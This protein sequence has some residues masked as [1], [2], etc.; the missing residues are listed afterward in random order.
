MKANNVNSV[1]AGEAVSGTP[2]ER[3]NDMLH[4]ASVIV[5]RAN[6]LGVSVEDVVSAVDKNGNKQFDAYGKAM[7]AG[8]TALVDMAKEAMAEVQA[9]G[10]VTSATFYATPEAVDGLPKGVEMEAETTGHQYFTDPLNRN[11]LTAQGYKTPDVSAITSQV[12]DVGPGLVAGD[13]QSGGMGP[14]MLGS[15]FKPSSAMPTPSVDVGYSQA[16]DLGLGP[17]RMPSVSYQ[18]GPKRPN[19]PDQSVVDSVQMAVESVM[20]PDARVSITSGKDDATQDGS[21]R[22]GTGLAVDVAVYDPPG[23]R[24]TVANNAQQLKDI[25]QAFS[26]ITGG[27]VG[28][29]YTENGVMTDT[30]HMDQVKNLSGLQDHEWGLIGNDPTYS[31]ALAEARQNKTMPGSYWDRVATH[32][33]DAGIV[34]SPRDALTPSIMSAYQPQ[35]AEANPFDALLNQPVTQAAIA[36]PVAPVQASASMSAMAAQPGASAAVEQ[37]ATPVKTTAVPASMPDMAQ[38]DDGRFGPPATPSLTDPGRLASGYSP[39]FGPAIAD[40]SSATVPQMTASATMGQPVTRGF[41]AAAAV[42]AMGQPRSTFADPAVVGSLNTE[43]DAMAASQQD[44]PGQLAQFSRASWNPAPSYDVNGAVAPMSVPGASTVAN[45]ANPGFWGDLAA[46]DNQ[47]SA[48]AALSPAS[49]AAARAA[50]ANPSQPFTAPVSASMSMPSAMPGASAKVGS[51]PS[52]MQTSNMAAGI[53]AQRD[54]VAPMSVPGAVLS[55]NFSQAYNS[56]TNGTVNATATDGFS[57]PSIAPNAGATIAGP[58]QANIPAQ[59]YAARPAVS[60]PAVQRQA[61]AAQQ[62]QKA[63]SSFLSTV[64]PGIVGTAMLG[65]GAGIIG[66]L[67]G[68]ALAKNGGLAGM[69]QNEP[70]TINN[71]GSGPTAMQGVYGPGAQRGNT[72]TANNGSTVTALGDGRVS[73]TSGKYGYNEVHDPNSAQGSVSA[74]W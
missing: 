28:L 50:M 45:V 53:N 74:V 38:F 25:G 13:P 72:F 42:P 8:T 2:E 23:N 60:Q 35:Q 49:D 51:V 14:S 26:A 54:F 16:N 43:L 41:E 47:Q 57:V 17:A 65:P 68:N 52:S 27:S 3:W 36:P 69:F 12:P 1:I 15:L 6:A 46:I 48:A 10:P 66:A 40:L 59:Q 61:P 19:M 30:F 64:L 4:I 22:H 56:A 55:P 9:N 29:G 11:I 21:N 20:G 63:Q 62:E 70:M 73:Y 31:A 58:A 24:L 34:P 71:L 5:N 44:N 7:P 39:N 67:L 32:V 18:M 33:T 37:L